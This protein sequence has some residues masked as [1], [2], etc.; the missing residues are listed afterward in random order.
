MTSHGALGRRDDILQYSVLRASRRKSDH[1]TSFGTTASLP[2]HLI[3]FA[4]PVDSRLTFI[5]F[6]QFIRASNRSHG[7]IASGELINLEP[8]HRSKSCVK[9]D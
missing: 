8:A 7:K 5:T 4:A 3:K 1:E 9:M 6:A 2:D